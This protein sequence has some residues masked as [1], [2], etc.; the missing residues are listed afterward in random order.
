MPPFAAAV[1]AL[2]GLIAIF[3]AVWAWQLKIGNAGMVDPVWAYSLGLVAVLY[4]VLGNG[5]PVSRALTAL[6]GLV[7]GVRLGTHL[8]KRNFG[9][10]EDARYRRFREEWGDKAASKMFWFFQVQVVISM[11]LSIA[12]LVPSYRS[13]AP[14]IGW[15]V[16]AVVVWIA[17]VVGE[18]I[19][20]RQLKHFTQDPANHTTVCRVGLWRYSRHPNYFFECVHWLA[21]IAL[22]IGTP[23]GWFTLLP[24][25]LM[26]F[27]LLKLSGIPL[28]EESMAKRRAG[29]ADYMRTTSALIPWPPRD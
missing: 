28:L 22:S 21:Y 19:A 7:W 2:I 16:L 13:S 11:L 18:G 6:G 3:S 27:L 1:I 12:F 17:S 26:A 4:A 14:A 24:P 15:I 8:W 5:D 20:D 9:K 25:V 29:Y 10:P 23:W